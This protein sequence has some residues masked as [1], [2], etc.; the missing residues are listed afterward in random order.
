MFGKKY[1]ADSVRRASEKINYYDSNK[2]DLFR[3]FPPSLSFGP[4]INGK[5]IRDKDFIKNADN[6]RQFGMGVCLKILE[7]FFNGSIKY[8]EQFYKDGMYKAFNRGFLENEGKAMY[9]TF[10]KSRNKASEF[11]KAGEDWADRFFIPNFIQNNMSLDDI[12][13]QQEYREALTERYISDPLSLEE[14]AMKAGISRA[15]H[16]AFLNEELEKFEDYFAITSWEEFGDY[17]SLSHEDRISEKPTFEIFWSI[18]VY[19]E[20]SKYLARQPIN[21]LIEFWAEI[22]NGTEPSVAQ[23]NILSDKEREENLT[24]TNADTKECPFCAET[25][26]FKAIKCRYCHEMLD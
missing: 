8:S 14:L 22:Q 13:A 15:K 25:I 24:E 16:K 6:N 26:K 1:S 23:S 20:L 19:R 11:F 7:Y 10:T 17:L 4:M 12:D 21:E 9:K 3:A 18:N 2:Y 5:T